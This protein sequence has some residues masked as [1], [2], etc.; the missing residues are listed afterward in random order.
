MGG[1]SETIK[2]EGQVSTET[3]SMKILKAIQEFV[4]RSKGADM[5]CEE[6]EP[7]TVDPEIVARATE[8]TATA[9]INTV[10]IIKGRAEETA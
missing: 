1:M 9:A 10:T 2:D 8:R 5:G 3:S 7:Y 6:A 4:E